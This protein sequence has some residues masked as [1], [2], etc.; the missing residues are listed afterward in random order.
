[1]NTYYGCMIALTNKENQNMKN[2]KGF[3][4]LEGLLLL[5]V[6][7]IIGGVGWY[8]WQSTKNVNQ[9]YYNASR[10]GTLVKG[11]LQKVA[12]KPITAEKLDTDKPVTQPN[13]SP[14]T[15]PK[16]QPTQPV[17]TP[18]PTT[19]CSPSGSNPTSTVLQNNGYTS[20]KKFYEALQFA[21]LVN[22]VDQDKTV[23]FAVNDWVFDNKLT[24]AQKD[25][26]FAS[27]QNMESVLK[28]QIV[29]SCL[30]WAGYM[31]SQ[32]GDVNIQTLGGTVTHHYGSPGN[33]DG[34]QMAMWDFFSSNGAV[35]LIT[36]FIKPPQVQ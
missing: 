25:Y 33:I 24:Q 7:A 5:V 34:V 1:M 6:V 36:G 23:V 2:Q 8:V 9:S 22:R 12:N 21:G 14:K 18:Q 11:D 15:Q 27:P 26:M 32:K 28:W 4:T 13:T 10:S 19:K 3:H 29:P 17:P 31:E 30:F 20:T 16:T 35:H